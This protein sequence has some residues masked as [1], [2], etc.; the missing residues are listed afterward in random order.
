MYY[1]GDGT[2]KS[3]IEAY[4]WFKAAARQGHMDAVNNLKEIILMCAML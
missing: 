2:S 1:Q 4:K 3:N